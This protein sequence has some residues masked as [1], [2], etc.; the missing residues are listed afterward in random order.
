GR[1]VRVCAEWRNNF[2]AFLAYVGK[3]PSK[4]HSLDR[5]PNKD[6]DYAP[7]NVRWATQHEQARNRRS[8]KLTALD[9]LG[10]RAWLVEGFSKAS[11][12]RAFGVSDVL[13]SFIANGKR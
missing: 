1:G 11:I 5:Y 13:I 12:A 8:T 2:D 9:V 6:G 3:R 7:G 10:I 4:R